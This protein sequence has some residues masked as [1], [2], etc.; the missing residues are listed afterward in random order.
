MD[1]NALLQGAMQDPA[2]RDFITKLL[3]GPDPRYAQMAQLAAQQRRGPDFSFMQGGGG[4]ETG[5]GA[6]DGAYS[7]MDELLKGFD[8][9]QAAAPQAPAGAPM[10]PP[11]MGAPSVAPAGPAAPSPMTGYMPGDVTSSPLPSQTGFST[12][13]IDELLKGLNGPPSA[14][15]YGPR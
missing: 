13:L 4:G 15:G 10:S 2:A 1:V 9:A 8:P 11:G 7:A 6:F 12:S 5:E 3:A 14:L